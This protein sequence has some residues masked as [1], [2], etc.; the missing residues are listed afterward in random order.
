MLDC[1]VI[2][3]RLE[4]SSSVRIKKFRLLVSIVQFSIEKQK[5]LESSEHVWCKIIL[6]SDLWHWQSLEGNYW[7][8]VRMRKFVV[9]SMHMTLITKLQAQVSKI[10]SPFD[11]T[12]TLQWRP[13]SIRRTMKQFWCNRR[14]NNRCFTH[15]C[16]V[17]LD[18]AYPQ[19]EGHHIWSLWIAMRNPN[20]RQNVLLPPTSFDGKH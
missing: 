17:A 20:K 6:Q 4:M 14:G 8:V 16:S 15:S 19:V 10:T 18:T 9:L 13:R 2:N 3:S 1:V 5:K 11:V 12:F 7:F